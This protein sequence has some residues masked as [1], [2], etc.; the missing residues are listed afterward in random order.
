MPTRFSFRLK[1]K[2]GKI[3]G[4]NRN[5]IGIQILVHLVPQKCK[6]NIEPE[7]YAEPSQSKFKRWMSPLFRS[8]D[9]MV[10]GSLCRGA[11]SRYHSRLFVRVQHQRLKINCQSQFL[12][13]KSSEIFSNS[14][15]LEEYQN[16]RPIL[17]MKYFESYDF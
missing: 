12:V 11:P 13:L 3:Q 10:G 17:I 2:T 7:L 6:F 14:F 15:F 16:W 8:K 9:F 4:Q 1:M 5:Y